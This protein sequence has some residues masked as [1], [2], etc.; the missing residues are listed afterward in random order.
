MWSKIS[1]R[2]L[3][4]SSVHSTRRQPTAAVIGELVQE[5]SNCL[6][7]FHADHS[8]TVG[9]AAP[10]SC[11]SERAICKCSGRLTP[12]ITC[13]R[14]HKSRGG[15]AAYRSSTVRRMQR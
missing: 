2:V 8:T 14:T 4:P 5:V 13:G 6:L 1:S 12:S 15:A 10:H 11:E 9:Q 7:G 3:R